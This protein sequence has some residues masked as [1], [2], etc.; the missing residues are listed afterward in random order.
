MHVNDG[1]GIEDEGED[2]EVLEMPLRAASQRAKSGEIVDGKTIM[3]LQHVALNDREGMPSMKPQLILIAGSFAVEPT[4]VR[5][6]L[7]TTCVDLNAAAFAVHQR[8]H[9]PLTEG[10]RRATISPDERGRTDRRCDQSGIPLS[11]CASD[12]L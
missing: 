3:L 10:G 7:S 8:C 1:G 9:M 6:P 12:D 11:G 5:F 4:A 2:L